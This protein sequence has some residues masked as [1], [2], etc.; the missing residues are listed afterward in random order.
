MVVS[1]DVFCDYPQDLERMR[2]Q[3]LSFVVDFKR[4]RLSGLFS[5]TCEDYIIN[6]NFTTTF[7]GY[8]SMKTDNQQCVNYTRPPPLLVMPP[9]Q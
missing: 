2:F 8:L 6:Y 1:C 5:Y 7:Y 4:Y 3:T 9:T